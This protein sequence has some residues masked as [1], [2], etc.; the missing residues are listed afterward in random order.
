MRSAPRSFPVLLLALPLVFA[1]PAAASASVGSVPPEV[2][3][4]VTGGGMVERLDDIYGTDAAGGGIDFDDTTA[5]GPISRVF[6]WTDARLAGDTEGKPVRM[7]NEW[8]VPVTIADEPV[9][10][11]IVWIN[12]DTEDPELA[13]FDPDPD[14]AVALAAVPDDAQL[15]RDVGGSAWFA[16]ADGTLT[17]LVPGTSGVTTPT[18]VDEVVLVTPGPDPEPATSDSGFTVAV[19]VALLLLAVIVVALLL[20]RWGRR[21]DEGDEPPAEPDASADPPAEEPPAQV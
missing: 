11:A 12:L 16:L 21:A 3:A 2:T 18:P 15:V 7:A 5:S 9:G 17:P 1:A 10:V 6:R 4:Y 20:P 13:E 8:A 14:A 19:V